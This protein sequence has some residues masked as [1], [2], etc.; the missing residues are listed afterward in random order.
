MHRYR[1][2]VR[3]PYERGCHIAPKKRDRHLST[4]EKTPHGYT[5]AM[6]LSAKQSG[7][8]LCIFGY[9]RPLNFSPIGR[10]CIPPEAGTQGYFSV[11]WGRPVLIDEGEGAVDTG[12]GYTTTR[13]LN[14]ERLSL[15]RHKSG[16]EYRR[17][18]GEART[19]LKRAQRVLDFA[20]TREVHS[21]LAAVDRTPRRRC[22]TKGRR[23]NSG[24]R[25]SA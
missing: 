23:K 6:G 13:H 7:G 2:S 20:E 16:V 19:H 9:A 12:G 15:P 1:G 25:R 5:S 17:L 21:A 10:R 24:V 18:N 11:A 4:F 8:G 22:N 14:R 3:A